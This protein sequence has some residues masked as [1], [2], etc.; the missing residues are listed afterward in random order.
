MPLLALLFNRR[1]C[2]ARTFRLLAVTS[3]GWVFLLILLA[4]THRLMLRIEMHL[5]EAIFNL[6]LCWLLL[7]TCWLLRAPSSEHNGSS[8]AALDYWIVS[9]GWV[10]DVF[11]VLEIQSIT[12][13]PWRRV[14]ADGPL[15]WHSIFVTVRSFD[16][17]IICALI[18]PRSKRMEW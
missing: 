13:I 12:L 5:S 16:R 4:D 6:S 14:V 8:G 2:L 15:C 1:S 7:R 9:Y 11:A 17:E 18:V 10:R 3:F